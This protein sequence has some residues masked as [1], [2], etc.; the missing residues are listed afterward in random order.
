MAKLN[1]NW[2][3]QFNKLGKNR[4]PF[5]FI[6]DFSGSKAL[7]SEDLFNENDILFDIN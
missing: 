7:I 5:F 2:E 1:F 6:I 4:Q 3:D